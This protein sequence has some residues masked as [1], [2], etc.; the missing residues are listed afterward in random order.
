MITN[1]EQHL[2]SFSIQPKPP[3]L[4]LGFSIVYYIKSY[5]LF[6]FPQFGLLSGFYGCSLTVLGLA[7][8]ITCFVYAYRL[9]KT[10]ENKL[11]ALWFVAGNVIAFSSTLFLVRTYNVD[12]NILLN[13][14]YLLK[15]LSSGGIAFSRYT[16]GIHTVLSISVLPL[17]FSMAKAI[18]LKLLPRIKFL[19]VEILTLLL[20]VFSSSFFHS[21]PILNIRF[22]EMA[23][24]QKWSEEWSLL[25][26]KLSNKS[27]Y[28]PVLMYPNRKQQICT[29]DMIVVF[30]SDSTQSCPD[31]SLLNDIN[32]IIV[33]N[34]A[35]VLK[36]KQI[37]LNLILSNK[38][39]LVIE[40]DY[41]FSAYYKFVVFTICKPMDVRDI[42][43]VDNEKVLIPPD[44]YRIISVKKN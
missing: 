20:F 24:T 23:K 28:I 25:S 5:T 12:S 8:I 6:L 1:H 44:H 7:L 32:T 26:Q 14:S 40:P 4:V 43:F 33:V 38:D 35:K 16:I 19:Y 3:L 22:W 18:S 37:K 30:D 9:F 11:L 31:Y 41:P 29:D 15:Y 17:L 42:N 27:F 39:S 21:T 2:T 10:A 34:D 36:N 13:S